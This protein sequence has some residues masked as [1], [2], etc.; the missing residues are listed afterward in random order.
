MKALT[1]CQPYAHLIA[2][3]AKRVE[4]RG[5]PT[6]Y[7]GH[8]AIH[9]GK[10]RNWL[11]LN[12]AGDMDEDY[13]IPLSEMD[14][15]AVIAT[16]VVADC[17]QADRIRQGQMEAKHFGLKDH[18]H[19]EGPWCW[20]LTEVVRLETPIPCKGA[21]GFWEFDEKFLKGA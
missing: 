5:W 6:K 12:E 8:I 13:E 1:I 20:I 9:A 16:A 21:Q 19:V 2:I 3:G 7:R 14:F 15:G 10:N 11:A 17:V 4:N 18:V